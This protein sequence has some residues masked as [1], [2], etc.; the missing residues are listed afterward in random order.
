MLRKWREIAAERK[1]QLQLF[2]K[3]LIKA[4][5]GSAADDVTEDIE[6]HSIGMRET[7]RGNTGRKVRQLNRPLDYFVRRL[8]SVQLD[9]GCRWGFPCRFLVEQFVKPLQHHFSIEITDSNK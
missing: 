4:R 1:H 7:D 6:R 8:F 2:T 9:E 5:A 3:L